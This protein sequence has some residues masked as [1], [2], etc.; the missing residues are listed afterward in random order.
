MTPGLT[1]S[2]ISAKLDDAAR[3]FMRLGIGLLVIFAG[4][5]LSA[6]SL[7]ALLLRP[8]RLMSPLLR[9]FSS[10]QVRAQFRS[11]TPRGTSTP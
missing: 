6:T 2:E 10:D 5:V 1:P 8:S 11:G 3:F 7:G 4:L 9:F